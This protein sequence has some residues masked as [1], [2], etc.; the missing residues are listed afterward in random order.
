[1]R[2]WLLATAAL[3]AVG[4]AVRQLS[5]DATAGSRLLSVTQGVDRGPGCTGSGSIAPYLH[6]MGSTTIR[7]HDAGVLDWWSY[8]PDPTKDPE[9]PASYNWTLGDAYFA[10]ILAT[11][12]TPYFRLGSSWSSPLW[13]VRPNATVFSRVAVNTLRHYNDGWDGGFTGK[14][15]KYWEIWNVRSEGETTVL[16]GCRRFQRACHRPAL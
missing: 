1:M 2:S 5:V 10:Q 7:T 4:Q 16:R 11:G 12:F 9:D 13:G 6:D 15:V 3:G 8:F 14:Q